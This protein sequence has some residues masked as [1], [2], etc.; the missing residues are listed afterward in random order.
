MGCPPTKSTV[1]GRYSSA[2][3][4]TSFL[5][6][7]TSVTTQPGGISEPMA[8]MRSL[9]A[10]TGVAKTRMSVSLM[11]G[12]SRASIRWN[13][14]DFSAPLR[15]LPSESVPTN[16]R[17]GRLAFLNA[18]AREVP[19]NPVPTIV[20][21]ATAVLLNQTFAHETGSGPEHF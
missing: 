12:N 17:L 9:I 14:R 5:V 21:L 3:S 1:L 2:H 13:A 7:P 11:A 19:I 16:S 4:K 15:T 20:I 18:I 8:S 10:M 6:L